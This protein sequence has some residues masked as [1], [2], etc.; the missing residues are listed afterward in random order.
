MAQYEMKDGKRV[1]VSRTQPN[2]AQAHLAPKPTTQ[3]EARGASTDQTK[4]TPKPGSKSARQ[5]A[6]DSSKEE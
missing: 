2:P 3:V 5:P 1:L 4:S 6:A